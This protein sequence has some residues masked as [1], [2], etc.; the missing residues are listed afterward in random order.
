VKLRG[1]IS[2]FGEVAARAHLPGWRTRDDLSIVAV[3]EPVSARRHEALRLIKNVR[4]Y[5]DL[6]LMLDGEALD[7][8]DIASP[9]ALHAAAA[10]AALQA[11]AH[12]IVEKPLSLGLAEFDELA[13]IARDNARVLMCVHNWKFAPPYAAAHDAII[14][15]RLGALR[16]AALDRF[17]VEPA[18][19]GSAGAKWRASAQTGG[20]ILI[21]HGWHVFYLM[22]WLMGDASPLA[23]SARLAPGAS[24]ATIA[25]EDLAD[26][27]VVFSDGRLARAHLSWRAPV[28]RTSAVLYGEKGMLEIDD[29]RVTFT[30]RDGAREDLS[31]ADAP[32]D[33]YHSSWFAAMAAAFERAIADGPAGAAA[34]ANLAEARDVLAMLV[35]ARESS[36]RDGVEV[37]IAM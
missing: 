8:V 12:V 27:R 7:F 37:A 22:R 32:D 16:Y 10:R 3:H 21:D 31:R 5:D 28:R 14:A 4:V 15:G 2:G 30:A 18:G 34:I 19:A 1:A 24:H 11:G 20:G 23:V 29:D 26:L 35:A 13:R 25:A 33:S 9:P 17:R 36:A 6:E